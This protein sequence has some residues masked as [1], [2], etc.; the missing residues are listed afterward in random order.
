M[1]E[2]EKNER[3][4]AIVEWIIGYAQPFRSVNNLQFKIMINKFDSRYQIPD[5]KTL[6]TMVVNYFKEKRINIKEDI[7]AIPGKLSLTADMWTSTC[8]NDAFLGLTIHYVDNNWSLRNFLLDIISFTT[9]HTGINIA[10][11]IKSVLAEFNT[12]LK[13]LWL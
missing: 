1:A 2:K 5:E 7:N 9:R 10:N 13:K 12:I 8:N 11:A 6:K 4:I 3:D